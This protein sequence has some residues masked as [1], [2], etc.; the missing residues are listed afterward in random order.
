[1]SGFTSKTT[2]A[3]DQLPVYQ[4][5]DTFEVK[6]HGEDSE[7]DWKG[8]KH[9]V[10]VDAVQIEDDLKLLGEDNV[11]KEWKSAVGEDG[12]LVNNTLSYI[13]AGDGVDTVDEIVKTESIKQKLVYTTVTYTN[14]T[15]EEMNHILYL[16]ELMLMDCEGDVYQIYYPEELLVLLS[17][18]DYDYVVW[19]GV[20]Q[21]KAGMS[22]Y[23]VYEE[24]DGNGIN[25]IPSLKPHE[26]IQ[27]N[28]AWIVNENVLDY[29]YLNLSNVGGPYEFS[30]DMSKAGVV[31]IC[32]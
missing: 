14:E 11:P 31:N 1:M 15:D 32:Q 28:M 12:K 30:D 10:S 19:D 5:G 21:H 8:C 6:T 17:G 26:S 3:S 29:M 20:A 13:K 24:Y 25:Y 7:G 18:E 23:S 22:Y 27:V 2:I 4:I 16:G 9:A